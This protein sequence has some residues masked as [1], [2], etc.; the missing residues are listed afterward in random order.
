MDCMHLERRSGLV[1]ATSPCSTDAELQEAV[2]WLVGQLEL[3]AYKLDDAR[4]RWSNKPFWSKERRELRRRNQH[5]SW[6]AEH[7]AI[8]G[9]EQ[10]R[11]QRIKYA[12]LLAST[13]ATA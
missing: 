1:Y 11:R 6:L 13:D 4:S 5:Y 9:F 2:D 10:A 8:A 3:H 7:A 12:S